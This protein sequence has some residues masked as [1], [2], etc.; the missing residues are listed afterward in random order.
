MPL[1]ARVCFPGKGAVVAVAGMSRSGMARDRDVAA[2]GERAQ[3]Y[4]EGWRGELH[5]QIADRTAGQGAHQAPG[6][7]VGN[8]SRIALAAVAPPVC[9]HHPGSD[10]H[11]IATASRA[12]S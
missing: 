9:R 6:N 7:P 2:F 4:D 8:G 5:H 10:S 1:G 3:G 12:L 11:Q